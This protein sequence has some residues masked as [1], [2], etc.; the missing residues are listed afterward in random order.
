MKD[1]YFLRDDI[2][3]ILPNI[4]QRIQYKYIDEFVNVYKDCAI[5]SDA[6]II[7][8][9]PHPQYTK[10][11]SKR[12]MQNYELVINLDKLWSGHILTFDVSRV[13][14]NFH[15][16]M[17]FN[18]IQ[19][20]IN[21]EQIQYNGGKILVIDD[22]ICSGRTQQFV[23]KLIKQQLNNDNVV[24]D[25]YGYANEDC[26]GYNMLDCNDMR[27]FIPGALNGGLVVDDNYEIHRICYL[28]PTIDLTKQSSIKESKTNDFRIAIKELNS[29]LLNVNGRN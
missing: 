21:L 26:I 19:H 11:V 22:D 6:E 20:N 17:K 24:I 10:L 25:W 3:Q 29:A 1:C 28:D 4:S 5:V 23:N 9:A 12:I 13:F 14:I 18:H 15:G 16:I 8:N 7:V 27:D 2:S